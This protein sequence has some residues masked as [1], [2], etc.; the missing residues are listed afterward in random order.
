M[1][2][3]LDREKQTAVLVQA[4]KQ[5]KQKKREQ[6]LCAIQHLQ[7]SGQPLTFPNIAQIAGCSVSYLYK[8]PELKAYIHDLQNHKTTHHKEL[9]KK[10]PGPHSLKTLHQVSKQRIRELEAQNQELKHQNQV[11][12]GHVAEIFELRSEC[13]RL[14]AQILKLT[15]PSHNPK[16]VPIQTKPHRASNTGND[17]LPQ[18]IVQSIQQ[19]GIKLGVRL[20]QEINKHDPNIVELAIKAFEQ[21]RSVN[22]VNNPGACLLAMIRDEAQPNVPTQQATK[23]DDEFDRWYSEAIEI[24]FCQNLPKNYLPTQN[25]KLMVRVVRDDLPAQYQLMFWREA[26]AV[27]EQKN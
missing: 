2:K 11:L 10:Q 7:N 19:M 15:Q 27:M 13:E 25:G 1:N 12:R 16:V 22:V 20:Q 26:K 17:N 21:Y 6:V 24:G 5:R 18:A 14:R 23:L 3:K 9:E 8:W 4:Q